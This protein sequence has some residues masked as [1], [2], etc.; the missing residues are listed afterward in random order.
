MDCKK[1]F[2]QGTVTPEVFHKLGIYDPSIDEYIK[3]LNISTYSK[4]YNTSFGDDSKYKSLS[5]PKITDASEKIEYL[6][7]RTGLKFE[8]LKVQKSYKVVLD[9]KAF[10]EENNIPLPNLMKSDFFQSFVSN[11]IGFVSYDNKSISLRDIS[12]QGGSSRFRIFQFDQIKRSPYM[13]IP[14]CN[15]DLLTD[16]PVIVLA[17]GAF[18]IMCIKEYFYSEYD[19]NIIYGAS[20]S[21]RALTKL[22]YLTGF[23]GGTVVVYADSSDFDLNEYKKIF[24]LFIPS[25]TLKLV[26]NQGGNDFGQIPEEGN[27]FDFKVFKM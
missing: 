24:S 13:Y 7:H 5:Y 10:Y 4:G 11:A 22:L 15:V 27:E 16:D 9:V 25:F 8:Q 3:K 23:F 20:S 17:E 18:D 6:K 12:K 2:V 21:K 1:C 19:T 26:V 14:P